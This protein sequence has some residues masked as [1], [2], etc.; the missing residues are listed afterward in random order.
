MF[1]KPTLKRKNKNRNTVYVKLPSDLQ[2][3]CHDCKGAFNLWKQQ[4][5]SDNGEV[6][7]V[8]RTKRK[9]Y[10]KHLRKILNQIEI[11]KAAKL[12]NAVQSN[13]KLFRKSSSQMS[14]FLTD[15]KMITDKNDIC[16]M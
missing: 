5:F 16:K 2:A 1:S 12:C 15:G 13:E 6:R 8:Y 11:D 9:E 7:N 10:G 3:A 14:A 4:D